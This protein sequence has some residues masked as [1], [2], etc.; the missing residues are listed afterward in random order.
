MAQIKKLEQKLYR[1][2]VPNDMRIDEIVKIV[3]AYGCE[4]RV[5]GKHPLIIVHVESGTII[6]IPKHGD[7]VAEAYIKQIKDLLDKIRAS[8]EII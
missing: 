3:K 1:K 7:T 8:E 5:G 4:T 6:P 2:P